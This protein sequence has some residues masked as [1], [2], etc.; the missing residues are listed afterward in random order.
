[1]NSPEYQQKGNCKGDEE[2]ME[3]Q[4]RLQSK[5]FKRQQSLKLHPGDTRWEATVRD[6]ISR[7]E[8]LRG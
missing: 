8:A 5:K 7:R 2:K 1:M 6:G 4:E 3:G